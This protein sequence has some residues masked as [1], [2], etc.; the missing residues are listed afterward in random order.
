MFSTNAIIRVRLSLMR[1]DRIVD[2]AIGDI[3]Y[4]HDKRMII[5]L[6]V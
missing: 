1:G 2:L 4:N 6:D 5:A 3:K